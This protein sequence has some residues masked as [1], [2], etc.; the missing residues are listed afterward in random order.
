MKPSR[1]ELLNPSLRVPAT[2]VRWYFL[3]DFY[4][5]PIAGLAIFQGRILRFCCFQEDI[6]YQR[7]YVLQELTPDE[8]AEAKRR[9]AKFE[10]M[11]GTVGSFDE[12]GAMLPAF[13]ADDESRA[14]FFEE[15]P[16]PDAPEPYDRPIA[17]WFEFP[18]Q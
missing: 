1:T 9:K 17:A 4:D 6:P 12:S 16:H 8:L 3:S 2:E 5:G 18:A 11:V 15:E 7:T 10:R 14:R 13:T